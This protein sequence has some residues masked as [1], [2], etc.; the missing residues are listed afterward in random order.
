MQEYHCVAQSTHFEIVLVLIPER[1]KLGFQNE[2]MSH[3]KMQ[4]S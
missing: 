4:Q 2:S 3:V 1:M